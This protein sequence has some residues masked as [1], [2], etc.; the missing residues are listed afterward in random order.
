METKNS[1]S[2]LNIM[3]VDVNLKTNQWKQKTK[4]KK[5]SQ[6]NLN[7]M[8]GDVDLKITQWKQNRKSHLNIMFG[9]NFFLICF[10]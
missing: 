9:I 7:I 2:H 1:Q 10:C 5:P 4:T 3:F 6:C 8:F